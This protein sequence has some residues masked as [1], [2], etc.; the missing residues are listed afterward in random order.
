MTHV[1]PVFILI[2]SFFYRISFTALY[3]LFEYDLESKIH[4][5]VVPT[6]L[7]L[8]YLL[9]GPYYSTK[10]VQFLSHFLLPVCYCGSFSCSLCYCI[11]LFCPSISE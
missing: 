10:Q 5:V 11:F 9:K 7:V 4:I 8:L 1:G 6:Q 2:F 3:S